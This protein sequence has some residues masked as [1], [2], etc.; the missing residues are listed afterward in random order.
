MVIYQVFH[1]EGMTKE[2]RAQMKNFPRMV[3]LVDAVE[4]RPNVAAFLKSDRY[5]G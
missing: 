2:G 3:K 5:Q 1:D 4:A